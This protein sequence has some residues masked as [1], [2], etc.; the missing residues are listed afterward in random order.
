ME[1]DHDTILKELK[2]KVFSPLYFL[3]GEE[4]Y[5]IDL[6]SKYAENHIL[7]DFEKDFNQTI[8]YGPET[9]VQVVLETVKRYPMMADKQLII[10]KEA[11]GLKKFE[12]LEVYFKNPIPTT[13]FMMCF[14]GKDPDKRKTY[15]KALK[16]NAILMESKRPYENKMPDWITN[17]LKPKNLTIHL[18]AAQ[19]IADF[20][21]NDLSK[22]AN[23]LDKLAILLPA[24]TE[25]NQ[26]HV[27][28]NIGI[29]KDF[30]VFELQKAIGLQDIYKCNLIVNHFASNMG[31]NPL[32]VIIANLYSYFT[33]IIKVHS[34]PDKTSQG[35]ATLLGVHPFFT[36][37]YIDASRNY[38]VRRLVGVI[39]TLAEYDKKSKGIGNATTP[40]SELLKEMI[41]KILH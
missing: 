4:S 27:E 35:L 36:K 3:Y 39:H 10:L 34:S 6:V 19:L 24:G 40:E 16:A 1:K 5:Y 7:E 12:D 38:N 29:S 41:Y 25:V 14:K 30:N 20:L 33:K 2:S 11:Q 15:Y 22:V 18:R 31:D 37:D 28:Q 13:I 26:G 21:G 9:T 23:E 17:Y 8:L 32:I